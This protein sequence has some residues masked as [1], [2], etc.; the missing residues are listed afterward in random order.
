LFSDS[1]RPEH[2]ATLFFAAYD[3][4]TH[5]LRYVNCG[6]PA[7]VIVRQDGEVELLDATSTVLGM[8]QDLGCEERIVRLTAGDRV[9]MFSDGFSEAKMDE[10]P[11]DWALMT[12]RRLARSHR[13]GLAG[14]LVGKATSENKMPE[15]DITVMDVR[16]L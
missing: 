12:I 15:D 7:P 11:D 1:T 13:N 14:A 16:V 6:H 3:S 8:F 10:E 2:Y 5:E 9:I 4:R